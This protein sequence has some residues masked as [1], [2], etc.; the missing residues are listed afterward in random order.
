MIYIVASVFVI[1]LFTA[2][3]FKAVKRNRG[4]AIWVANLVNPSTMFFAMIGLALDLYSIADGFGAANQSEMMNTMAHLFAAIANKVALLA[5][6]NFLSKILFNIIDYLVPDDSFNPLKEELQKALGVIDSQISSVGLTSNAKIDELSENLSVMTHE[7]EN[8]KKSILTLSKSVSDLD[9][10]M[11]K[12]EENVEKRLQPV[13]Q[14]V[15]ESISSCTDEVN[16][17]RDN[18]VAAGNKIVDAVDD[19]SKSAIKNFE[20][21]AADIIEAANNAASTV[22]EEVSSNLNSATTKIRNDV[23]CELTSAIKSMRDTAAELMENKSND[24]KDEMVKDFETV[25]FKFVNHTVESIEHIAS[26]ADQKFS[27]LKKNITMSV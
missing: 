6:G 1:T 20:N 18:F 11:E 19:I 3:S 16:S 4:S 26:A 27:E 12:I 9:N 2:S 23:N 22:S 10:K 5:C 17:A 21:S 14:K 7:S 25:T 24:I 8:I 15:E 13:L